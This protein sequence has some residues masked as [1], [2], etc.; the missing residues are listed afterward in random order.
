MPVPYERTNRLQY[1]TAGAPRTPRRHPGPPTL[2]T[3]KPPHP[4]AHTVTT[5]PPPPPHP[6]LIGGGLAATTPQQG[7]PHEQCVDGGGGFLG[8]S[9]L[10]LD[11]AGAQDMT[12]GQAAPTVMV[13]AGGGQQHTGGGQVHLSGFLS[14]SFLGSFLG[15]GGLSSLGLVGGGGRQPVIMGI[16]IGTHTVGIIIPPI[17]IPI[18]PPGII[19]PGMPMPGIPIPGMT[20]IMPGGHTPGAGGLSLSSFLGAGGFFSSSF[21]SALG[22]GG[23]GAGAHVHTVIGGGGQV[24]TG[25][26]G[27]VQTATVVAGG[28]VHRGGHVQGGGAAGCAHVHTTVGTAG[29]RAPAHVHM[30]GEAQPHFAAASSSHLRM[31]VARERYALAC[32]RRFSLSV[33]SSSTPRAFISDSTAATYERYASRP[34]AMDLWLQVAASA[35]IAARAT[36][37]PCSMN[38]VDAD[39]TVAAGAMA[40]ARPQQ[41]EE[42]RTARIRG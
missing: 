32:T 40:P 38:A 13:T 22:L 17:P 16:I 23:I 35:A 10:G 15:A 24:H 28:Q 14:S 1:G 3:Q 39:G 9:A 2:V 25:G 33:L 20:G 12:V 26:G 29:G 19:I 41:K 34:A 30:A 18:M 8:G 5:P 11:G 27:Q 42:E 7:P 4:P 21:F 37:R 6:Q 36:A 31:T